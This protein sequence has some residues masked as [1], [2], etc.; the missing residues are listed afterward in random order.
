[1]AWASSL[2]QHRWRVSA[3]MGGTY[4]VF[5]IWTHA[6]IFSLKII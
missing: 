1:M 4:V 3:G 5:K 6:D 2:S